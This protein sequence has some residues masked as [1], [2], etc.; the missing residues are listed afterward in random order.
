MAL[1]GNSEQTLPNVSATA[2]AT[3]HCHVPSIVHPLYA[4]CS[5]VNATL[6]SGLLA[7]IMAFLLS[8][9]ELADMM[10]IGTLM[11][12]TMVGA[13]VIILRYEV[14]NA[15]ASHHLL[16]E[17]GEEGE[18]GL[19]V[20]DLGAVDAMGGIDAATG[21]IRGARGVFAETPPALH[22]FGQTSH[23]GDSAARSRTMSAGGA[24]GGVGRHLDSNYNTAVTPVGSVPEAR[25]ERVLAA[26]GTSKG[27]GKTHGDYAALDDGM[28]EEEHELRTHSST[29]D[30]AAKRTATGG[31]GTVSTG[32]TGA[33]RVDSLRASPSDG[34]LNA[35]PT[36]GAV[37]LATAHTPDTVTAAAAR[38]LASERSVLLAGGTAEKAVHI[39]ASWW[40][41]F[42]AAQTFKAEHTNRFRAVVAN[43]LLYTFFT[44]VVAVGI[45]VG[46]A[47][48]S[49]W[50]YIVVGVFGAGAAW[51]M[52]VMANVPEVPQPQ[53][54]FKC[55]WVPLL[56]MT[57]MGVNVYLLA[58]LSVYTWIRFAIWTVIGFAIYFWYGVHNSRASAHAAKMEAEQAAKA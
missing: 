57:S 23:D 1:A 15:N 14:P 18:G 28:E 7:G 39:N 46:V 8:I 2:T 34:S 3:A 40:E 13:C 43:V 54:K 53:L 44:V 32:S 45:N 49:L 58:S 33:S 26:A 16:E 9:D 20:G 17:E 47:E 51:Q 27:P 55:P 22:R 29:S 35:G 5:P 31:S 38:E 6:V 25:G 12:Y 41:A 11:S 30:S 4:C 36:E 50:G 42:V 48:G 10:S 52:V 24:G 56:P 21:I 19:K 37:M